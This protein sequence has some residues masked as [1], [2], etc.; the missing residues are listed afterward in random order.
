MHVLDDSAC[1][2]RRVWQPRHVCRTRLSAT[3]F[4][5]RETAVAHLLH[6]IAALSIFCIFCTVVCAQLSSSLLRFVRLELGCELTAG[7]A[8]R[9]VFPPSGTASLESGAS[10]LAFGR[11]SSQRLKQAAGVE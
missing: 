2:A 6:V 10:V 4:L 11:K 7:A 8:A 3:R 5:G 1:C 9:F